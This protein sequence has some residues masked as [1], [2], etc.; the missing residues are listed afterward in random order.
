MSFGTVVR[1]SAGGKRGEQNIHGDLAIRRVVFKKDTQR[2]R[3]TDT[4]SS[5]DSNRA[6]FSAI[7]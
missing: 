2:I 6:N 3:K 1:D 5:H 4:T 7:E